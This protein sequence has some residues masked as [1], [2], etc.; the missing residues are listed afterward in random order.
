[1]YV[2][3]YIYIYIQK[4]IYIIYIYIYF[5][6]IFIYNIAIKFLE[7]KNAISLANGMPNAKMFPF[8]E[9]SVIYKD[10]TKVKLIGEELSWSLQYG[11]SQG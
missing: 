6:I 2:C 11:P 5:I 9:I 10:G 7:S 4:F 1:M 3:I 8:K